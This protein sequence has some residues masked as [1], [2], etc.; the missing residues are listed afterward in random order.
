VLKVSRFRNTTDLYR[1]APGM[2][3]EKFDTQLKFYEFALKDQFYL[4]IL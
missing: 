1:Q 3:F 4:K 2:I